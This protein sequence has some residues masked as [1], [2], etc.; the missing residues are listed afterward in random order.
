MQKKKK[1]RAGLGMHAL[2]THVLVISARAVHSTQQEN[3]QVQYALCRICVGTSFATPSGLAKRAVPSHPSSGGRAVQCSLRS[4]MELLH[5]N[6]RREHACTQVKTQTTT[7][8]RDLLI[9]AVLFVLSRLS[10][11][12]SALTLFDLG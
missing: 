5:V 6:R 10:S 7:S 9:R 8:G 11:S 3:V 2:P 12:P 1:N 4:R